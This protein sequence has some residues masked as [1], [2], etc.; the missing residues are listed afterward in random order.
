MHVGNEQIWVGLCVLGDYFGYGGTPAQE[1]VRLASFVK[2]IVMSIPVTGANYGHLMALAIYREVSHVST[3]AQ[4]TDV[5]SLS[6][7]KE[8]TTCIITTE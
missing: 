6:R 2:L 1:C 7:M 3:G 8:G 4:A 5:M